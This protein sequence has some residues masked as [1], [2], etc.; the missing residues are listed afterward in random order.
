M[1]YLIAVALAHGLFLPE[2][3]TLPI[4]LSVVAVAEVVHDQMAPIQ[5]SEQEVV[6]QVESLQQVLSQQLQDP[7]SHLPL[8]LAVVAVL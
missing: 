8:E 3:Q 1:Q 6:E 7:R 2:L 4:L 5:I